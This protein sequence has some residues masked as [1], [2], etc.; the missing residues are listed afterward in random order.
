MESRH[1][2]L[3]IQILLEAGEGVVDG[4]RVAFRFRSRFATRCWAWSRSAW[5]NGV[6][7]HRTISVSVQ[8]CSML[9]GGNGTSAYC[10]RPSNWERQMFVE[11][12]SPIRLT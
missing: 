8:P 12:Q 4:G 5:E 6:C 2:R 9:P 11:E 10:S 1:S 3:L 7:S